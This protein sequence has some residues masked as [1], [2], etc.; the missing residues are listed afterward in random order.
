MGGSGLSGKRIS[1]IWSIP[2]KEFLKNIENSISMSEA[3]IK[4]GL[5]NKSGNYKTLNKRIKEEQI[6]ISHFNN[7]EKFKSPLKVKKPLEQ[8]L[9]K[10]SNHNSNHLKKR[11]LEEKILKNE[12]N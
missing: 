10:N 4:C 2:K 12:C 9:V 5:T 8:V 3:L 11:L 7:T 6:D 1:P